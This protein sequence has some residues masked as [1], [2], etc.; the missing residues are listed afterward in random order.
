MGPPEGGTP[1]AFRG[2]FTV[3]ELLLAVSMMSLVVIALFSVFNQTQKALLGSVA[4]TDVLEAGRAAMDLM[5]ND[6]QQTAPSGLDHGPGLWS[7]L[8]PTDSPLVQLLVGG[9]ARTNF[10]NEFFF[11][12]R[13]NATWLG[14]GYFVADATDPTRPVGK[15]GVGMLYRFSAPNAAPWTPTNRLNTNLLVQLQ[16]Q[17]LNAQ[18]DQLF[19]R[20]H[21]FPVADGII[22]LRLRAYDFIGDSMTVTNQRYYPRILWAQ[23]YPFFNMKAPPNVFITKDVVP[24][25]TQFSFTSNTLPAYLELELGILEPQTLDRMKAMPNAGMALSFLTN[26]AGKVHLFRRRIPIPTGTLR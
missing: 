20:L 24:T 26:Q 7:R 13:S 18:K 14:N 21:A 16:L 19:A 3:L 4:Q 8:S 5:V 23:Y 12:T 6:L 11:L 17:F 1:N 9:D 15:S 10:L 2:G 22:H 25:E